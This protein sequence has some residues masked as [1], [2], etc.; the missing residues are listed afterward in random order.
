M[1]R[2]GERGRKV[3]I[4]S[5]YIHTY[6][7]VYMSVRIEIKCQGSRRR[8]EQET[9]QLTDSLKIF[10]KGGREERVKARFECW[11]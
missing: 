4:Y 1:K 7:Q 6:M 10:L 2:E 9:G 5:T 11:F 3:Q 8:V